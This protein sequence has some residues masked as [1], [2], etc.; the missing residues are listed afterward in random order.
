MNPNSWMDLLF[1]IVLFLIGLYSVYT[2]FRNFQL[3]QRIKNTAVSKAGSVAVGLVEISGR[4]SSDAP[5]PAPISG[6]PCVYWKITGEYLFPGRDPVWLQIHAA[7]SQQRFFVTDETGRIRINPNGA[8]MDI[9]VSMYCN[10]S[11]GSELFSKNCIPVLDEQRV[12]KY[13]N[14]LD[15]DNKEPFIEHGM[16]PIRLTE[17]S[18]PDNGPLYIMGSA[19]PLIDASS[20]GPKE[21]LEIR[22]S[23]IYKTLYIN[24]SGKRQAVKTVSSGLSFRI[25]GGIFLCAVTLFGMTLLP[26]LD[27]HDAGFMGANIML[28]VMACVAVYAFKVIRNE[29]K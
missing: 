20:A 12:T 7:E 28:F 26:G 18:I 5:G 22:K 9:P 27:D 1:L 23:D 8:K 4:A 3:A 2:G 14:S 15:Y 16:R 11:A 25:F 10:T 29:M 13:I 17:Y 24:T 21:T 19:E 6:T